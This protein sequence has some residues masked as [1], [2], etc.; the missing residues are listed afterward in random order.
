[1]RKIECQEELGGG[2]EGEVRIMSNAE[3]LMKVLKS[4]E[5]R[6]MSEEEAYA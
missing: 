5:E 1:M 6:R 3:E 2:E 4:I